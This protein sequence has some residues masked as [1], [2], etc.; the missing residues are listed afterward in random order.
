MKMSEREQYHALIKEFFENIKL[1]LFFEVDKEK[2]RTN[3]KNVSNDFRNKVIVEY[4]KKHLKNKKYALIKKNIKTISLMKNKFGNIEKHI[5]NV[6]K[7]YNEKETDLMIFS[8]LMTYFK[9]NGFDNKFVKEKVKQTKLDLLYIPIDHIHH[10]FNSDEDLQSTVSIFINTE[11]EEL[12][13]DLIRKQNY[14]KIN[15]I[16]K[17]DELNN[18]HYS[19][20][21]IN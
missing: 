7:T 20:S 9:E 10:S 3:R 4:S 12:F 13:D 2:Q 14:F 5:D 1:H 15:L 16:E 18:Y 21:K 6:L 8:N 11:N 17:N 19:I